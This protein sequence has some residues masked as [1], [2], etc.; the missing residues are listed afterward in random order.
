MGFDFKNVSQEE[1]FEARQKAVNLPCWPNKNSICDDGNFVI[2][3]N[4]RP[5]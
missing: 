3:K 4:L 5:Y 1:M 2:V